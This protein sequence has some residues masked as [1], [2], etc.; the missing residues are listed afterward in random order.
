MVVSR[1]M[2]MAKRPA[3]L[4]A[5]ALCA[6]VLALGACDWLPDETAPRSDAARSEVDPKL[7]AGHPARV[8]VSKKDPDPE[9]NPDAGGSA[10]PARLV[11]ELL[12]VEVAPTERFMVEAFLGN[13]MPPAG[14]DKSSPGYVGTFG[15]FGARKDKT[16]RFTLALPEAL[17]T[18]LAASPGRRD[19]GCPAPNQPLIATLRLQ[20]LGEQ[21]KEL[22]SHFDVQS[23]EIVN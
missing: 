16:L 22:T 10:A 5:A 7:T 6:S 15:V 2:P 1:Q 20:P 12:A 19:A 8:A 9:T 17:R 21:A 23:A 14:A 4:L 13:T 3:R 11:L 18:C